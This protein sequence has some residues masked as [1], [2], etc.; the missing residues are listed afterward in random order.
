[1]SGSSTLKPTESPKPSPL[2]IGVPRRSGGGGGLSGL[3]SQIK[4]K[5][6]KLSTLEKS[7][8]DWQNFKSK[9]GITEEIQTHNRGKQGCAFFPLGFPNAKFLNSNL[10]ARQVSRETRLFGKS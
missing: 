5:G 7:Q 9:E 8:M 6:T 10:F 3:M 2:P 4:G 1:M